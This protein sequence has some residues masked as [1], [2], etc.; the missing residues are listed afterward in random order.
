M[1]ASNDYDPSALVKDGDVVYVSMNYR[2]NVF[3]FFAHPA[4]NAEGHAAGNYGIMDQKSLNF[5]NLPPVRSLPKWLPINHLFT[6]PQSS[7]QHCQA[8]S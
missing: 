3:G 6:S 5:H 8:N 4:I 7:R 2:L 1:G